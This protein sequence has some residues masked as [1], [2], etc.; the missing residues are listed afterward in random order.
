MQVKFQFLFWKDI[1][2]IHYYLNLSFLT[3]TYRYNSKSLAIF[4]YTYRIG[5][6]VFYA[7]KFFRITMASSREVGLLI[8][9]LLR[10]ITLSAPKTSSF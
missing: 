6:I 1:L 3:P 4:A 8:N 2:L 5:K 9:S 10:D 7:I